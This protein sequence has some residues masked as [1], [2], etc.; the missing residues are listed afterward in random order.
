MAAVTTP[1]G[2]EAQPTPPAAASSAQFTPP[3]NQALPP[4][5]ALGILP[6]LSEL[7][8]KVRPAVASIDVESVTRGIFFDFTD[9]GAGTGIVVRPD[10]YIVTNF[11]V[12]QDASRIRVV[13]PDGKSYDA[14]V[15]GLDIVTDLAILKIAAQGLPTATFGDSDALKV[16]DWVLALGNALALKGGPTVTL[17]IVSA[18]GRTVNTERGQLYDM[19]QTDAPINDGNSGGPLVNLNGEVVGISTAILRD[20]QGIG[21]AVSS[22]TARPIIDALIERGHVVRPLIG[23]TGTDL[24]PARASQLGISARIEGIIVTRAPADGPAYR[25]GIRVGDVVTSMNGTP[26]PDMA[27]FLTL[28]W[29]YKAGDKVRLEAIRNNQPFT[30]EVQLEERNG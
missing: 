11:H 3:V 23:L 25:A 8:E 12:V 27:R 18:R 5:S 22:K 30:A 7:V 13:L 20:A 9:Q 4:P 26:T 19:I 16:G 2:S 6:S 17:G 24:T 1:N 21:F 14:Q 15:V 29:T 28:L 10:G